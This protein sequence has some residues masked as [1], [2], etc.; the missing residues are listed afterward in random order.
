MSVSCVRC[1]A[2]YLYVGLGNVRNRIEGFSN[3]YLTWPA[4]IVFSSLRHGVYTLW[5]YWGLY[6]AMWT[7]V[8]QNVSNCVLL[9]NVVMFCSIASAEDAAEEIGRA[10]LMTVF[11]CKCCRWLMV[12]VRRHHCFQTAN[13]VVALFAFEK[14]RCLFSLSYSNTLRFIAAQIIAPMYCLNGNETKWKR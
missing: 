5:E 11:L 8:F 4:W 10:R 6:N 14:F 3:V 12:D 9:Q 2:N 1:S 7:P 13:A